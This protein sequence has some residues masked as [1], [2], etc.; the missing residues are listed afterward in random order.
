MYDFYGALLRQVFFGNSERLL[1]RGV[2]G[3]MRELCGSERYGCLGA[4]IL[5]A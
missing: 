2:M 3:N 4:Q 1:K 5:S